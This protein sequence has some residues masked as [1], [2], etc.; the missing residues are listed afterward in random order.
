MARFQ[1]APD[2]DIPSCQAFTGR[3]FTGSDSGV[4]ARPRADAGRPQ[5]RPLHGPRRLPSWLGGCLA[6]ALFVGTGALVIG[7]LLE[8][9]SELVELGHHRDGAE[10]RGR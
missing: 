9:T 2:D 4:W 7:T 10:G 1:N 5:D 3:A 8:L 6:L